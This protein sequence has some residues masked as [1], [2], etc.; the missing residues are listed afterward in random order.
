MTAG[1]FPPS[2]AAQVTHYANSSNSAFASFRSRVSNPSVIFPQSARIR[3][4]IADAILGWQLL[5]FDL[6]ISA[7][8]KLVLNVRPKRERLSAQARRSPTR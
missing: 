7:Y 3:I 4:H 8:Q 2:L 1:R 6:G 5:R